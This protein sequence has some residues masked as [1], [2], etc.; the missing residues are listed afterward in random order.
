LHY[1]EF[2]RQV[3]RVA[4]GGL[5]Q[6]GS[7]RAIVATLATLAERISPGT[8]ADLAAQL[9]KQLKAALRGARPAGP[10]GLEGFVHSAAE[11][12]GLSSSE[13]LDRARAVVSVLAQAVTGH[14]LERVRAE[15]G[16]GYDALFRPPAAVRWPDSH[17]SPP[18][19]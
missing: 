4:P 8:A 6:G 11:R 12:Q 1:E 2:V 7:E 3:E 5:D 15:L 18:H 19:P 17:T 13:A 14:E 9:P 16:E 10:P